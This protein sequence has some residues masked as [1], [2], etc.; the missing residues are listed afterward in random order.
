MRQGCQG[1]TVGVCRMQVGAVAASAIA[2]LEAAL[3]GSSSAANLSLLSPKALAGQQGTPPLQA[4]SAA[5]KLVS[6]GCSG[7]GMPE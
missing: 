2:V 5:A 4:G 3:N 6:T 7:F 1:L